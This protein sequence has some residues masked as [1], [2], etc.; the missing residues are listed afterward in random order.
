MTVQF[1]PGDVVRLKCGGPSMV[2]AREDEPPEPLPGVTDWPAEKFRP[3]C[4]LVHW[5]VQGAL[6]SAVLPFEVLEL[7][8]Q[9]NTPT[10]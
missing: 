10:G 6:R 9:A 2:L 7:V 8:P 5:T 4:W 1:Q 3:G